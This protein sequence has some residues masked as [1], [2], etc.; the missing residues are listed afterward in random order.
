M[1]IYVLGVCGTFMGGLAQ[2]A[3]QKGFEV[4]GCD[5]NAYPPMSNVLAEQGIKVDQG[6]STRNIADDI[7]LFVIGNV[8][9]RGNPMMEEILKRRLKFVSGPQFLTE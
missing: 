7:D 6:F 9:S 8:V 3:V 2:L 4:A 5:E 1:K